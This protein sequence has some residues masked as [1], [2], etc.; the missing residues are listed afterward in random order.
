[1]GVGVSVEV[2][3]RV[4]C[5]IVIRKERASKREGEERREKRRE[6]RERERSNK[7][8][9]TT[10]AYSSETYHHE[11]DTPDDELKASTIFG[12]V[13]VGVKLPIDNPRKDVRDSAPTNRTNELQN[14]P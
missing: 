3:Q 12:C 2:G 7:H 4:E 1:M 8:C 9:H 6:E 13:S 10:I 14:D 5:E 11:D